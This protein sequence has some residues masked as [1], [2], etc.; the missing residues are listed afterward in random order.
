MLSSCAILC[1]IV[2]VG[3]QHHTPF[4]PI[5][6]GHD[7]GQRLAPVVRLTSARK[8]SRPILTPSRIGTSCWRLCARRGMVPSPPSVISMSSRGAVSRRA[9]MPSLVPGRVQ[10]F[11]PF[12]M[13]VL[14]HL[15]GQWKRVG[16]A[17]GAECRRCARGAV[18]AAVDCFPWRVMAPAV[19]SAVLAARRLPV[20]RSTGCCWPSARLRTVSCP[21]ASSPSPIMTTKATLARLADLVALEATVTEGQHCADARPATADQGHGRL[22]CPPADP[23]FPV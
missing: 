6:A 12:S 19:N 18:P 15:L 1:A 8:P 22:L 3:I 7:A 23:S 14:R 10:P 4:Q 9:V 17:G 20:P 11:P 5:I 13:D 21:L 16:F 2:P